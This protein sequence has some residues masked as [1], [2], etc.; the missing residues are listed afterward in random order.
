MSLPCPVSLCPPCLVLR[1]TTLA[2]FC[3]LEVSPPRAKGIIFYPPPSLYLLHFFFVFSLLFGSK[4]WQWWLGVRQSTELGKFLLS[5]LEC[6]AFWFFSLT[7]NMLRAK[8]GLLKKTALSLSLSHSL[9]IFLSRLD[10]ITHGIM[11]RNFQFFLISCLTY[12]WLH[13]LSI[14]CLFDKYFGWT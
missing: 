3:F 9:T 10:W 11:F 1:F 2:N 13:V 12:F 7:S 5:L 6:F 14:R 4:I 8:K